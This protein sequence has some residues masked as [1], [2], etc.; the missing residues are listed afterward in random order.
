MVYLGG[1]G[2][3]AGSILGATIYTVLL[4][5]LRPLEIWRMVLMPLMLVLLMIFRPRGIM[6]MREFPW[7]V[8]AR[9]WAAAVARRRGERAADAP[10][11]G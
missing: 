8:P 3:I 5:L 9:E 4:E 10:A 11:E 1:I 7:F 6:G 2:S